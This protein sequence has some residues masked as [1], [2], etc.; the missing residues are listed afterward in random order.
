MSTNRSRRENLV[1]V[2]N[3]MAGMACV[4]EIFR[5]DPER[6]D[7]TIFGK[8]KHP[9]YNRILLSYV[10]TG[11]KK[12]DDIILQDLGW[13]RER[14]I[15]LYGG[16]NVREIRRSRRLVVGEDGSEA[17]YNKLIIATGSRP[18]LPPVPGIDK[19]GVL[20]F[21]DIEDCERIKDASAA[22]RRAVV[23]G[24]GILGLEAAYGLMKLGMEVTVVH[25]M[26][27]LMERQLDRLA[28]DFLKEDLERLGIKILLNMETVELTGGKRVDGLRFSDGSS[29]DTDIVVVAVG[30]RPNKELAE[31]AG[32][33]S[34][35]GIV[36]SD[37][38]QTYDPA[39]YAVGECVQ[40]RGEVFGLVAPIFEQARVLAN[41]LAGDS[42]LIFKSRPVSTKLKIPE[43]DLYCGG[44]IDEGDGIESIEYADRGKRV[45][46]RLFLKDNRVEGLVLYG[47]TADGARLF[48]YLLDGDDISE[49]RGYVLFGE[50]LGGRAHSSI[51]S[52]PDE[53]I[54]CGC[55]GVTKAVIVG[56]IE[57]KGLFT[58]EDVKAE[59][60]AASSCG[61][62]AQVVEQ[63][64]EAVL[65]SNFQ[66]QDAIKSICSC[67]KYTR[68]DI[69]KNIRERELKSVR[70]VMETLG[71]ETVG[72]DGCRPAINYYLSMVWPKEYEDDPTSRLVNERL[73]AN[74]QRDGTFSV[75]P[76]MYGGATTA[77][78]LRRIADVAEKYHVRLVK[79]TGGQRLDLI[80]IDKDDLPAVWRDLNMPSGYAYGKALRTV[81]TCV[82]AEFC[83]Y[84]TQ[85][86]M[87]LGIDLEK[88]LEGLWAPAKIKIGVTGCPRNCAESA[89]KDIG[90][91]GISGGWEVYVGGCGGINLR[92]GDLLAS[93]KT[94]EEVMEMACAFIQYYREDAT[95]GERTYAWIKRIGLEKVRN[96]IVDDPHNRQILLERL[97][98]ALGTIKDPWRERVEIAG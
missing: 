20:T 11:E 70:E 50:G 93:V 86:S 71:W 5:L 72:C 91:V 54:I 96:A 68:E 88:R 55:N 27:R 7:V 43:I 94:S 59:T 52:L 6:Y 40:H 73:H 90:I 30:I 22:S 41:H 19:E 83:R 51:E 64:L 66:G 48:Q 14:G 58:L 49:R 24:G 31:G 78:E 65:G 36:V 61:G 28:A 35:R 17:H 32:I 77:G 21:R 95:Y 92:G 80:G 12:V 79:I 67:T 74:I 29:I 62:C 26:D 37:T 44:R 39:V 38:M 3:G 8:E 97:D 85:D 10:L 46:K 2:G 34:E 13:Y 60:K 1:V 81:K 63:I 33:Y 16:C 82:G 56:A 47:D 18:F 87:N 25:L 89:I 84:G 42:R 98:E 75:V 76:R 15:R 4:E 23:I 53:A 9:N 45:Y 69:I 57:E